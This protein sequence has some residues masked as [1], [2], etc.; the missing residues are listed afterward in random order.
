MFDQNF[1]CVWV[2]FLGNFGKIFA[3]LDK[4]RQVFWA[5]SP[6]LF[7]KEMNKKSGEVVREQF[8]LVL[9][10]FNKVFDQFLTEI[11]KVR[12]ALLK[13]LS[14]KQHKLSKSSGLLKD[15]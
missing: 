12:H 11:K 9:D 15:S 8:L 4:F 6:E 2:R 3:D 7:N 10:N 5:T 1:F 14:R 13:R